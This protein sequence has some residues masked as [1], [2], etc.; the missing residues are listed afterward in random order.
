MNNLSSLKTS[1][2]SLSEA[3][4]KKFKY[5]SLQFYKLK[6]IGKNLAHLFVIVWKCVCV[7]TKQMMQSDAVVQSYL[8]TLSYIGL[9]TYFPI[10][11]FY[12]GQVHLAK[13]CCNS[14]LVEFQFSPMSYRTVGLEATWSITCLAVVGNG[15]SKASLAAISPQ[16]RFH[17]GLED[18]GPK[19]GC[20]LEGNGAGTFNFPS[21]CVL[22]MQ[23]F[24]A[25]MEVWECNHHISPH[26]RAINYYFF[27]FKCWNASLLVK[28]HSSY[29][30][31]AQGLKT[32][33][34]ILW[35]LFSRPAPRALTSS[36]PGAS[37]ALWNTEDVGF[38]L[39]TRLFWSI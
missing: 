6:G 29:S 25:G 31:K 11:E 21:C 27:Y 23:Y 33:G 34:E 13:G 39:K 15:Q 30:C 3:L 4:W 1:K 2:S 16:C 32:E 20:F 37:R 38:L 22:V 18:R 35:V 9:F 12:F 5:L 19:T 24:R 8:S 14:D 36:C 26:C 10:C 17:S 7:V 28:G